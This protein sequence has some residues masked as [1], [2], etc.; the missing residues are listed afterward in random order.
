MRASGEKKIVYRVSL[1]RLLDVM[2]RDDDRFVAV[3]GDLDQVI[4]DTVG[5][6]KRKRIFITCHSTLCALEC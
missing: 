2:R 1:S 6:R 3:F 5:Q 4:P